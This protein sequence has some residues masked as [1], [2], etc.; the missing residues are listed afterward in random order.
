MNRFARSLEQ[1]TLGKKL[2]SGFILLMLF[3]IGVGLINLRAQQTLIA[4]IKQLNDKEL[5]GVSAARAAQVQYSTIGRGLR[6]ALLAGSGPE[7]VIALKEIDE[8]EIALG[9]DINELRATLHQ[10]VNMRRLQTFETELA[11]Y[12][13]NREKVLELM[14]VGH[15]EA[16]RVYLTSAEF[17]APGVAANTAITELAEAKEKQA[18][19][20]VDRAIAEAAHMVR[21]AVMLLTLGTVLSVLIALLVARSIRKPIASIQRA[22]QKLADG[23]L[24]AQVPCTDYANEL[25]EVARSVRVLQQGATAMDNMSWVKGNL[26]EISN[27][28]QSVNSFSELSQALF[29]Q[30]APLVH[31]GHGAFYIHEEDG[32]RLRLLGGYALRE[33]KELNQYFRIGEGLVGQCAMERD[34]ILLTQPPP[35]YVRIGSSLGDAAPVMIAVLPVLRNER[36]LGVLELATYEPLTERQQSL[37]DGV[38]PTLA[39]NLEILERSVRT[40]KLLEETQRQ[41]SAMQEQAATLEE[42]AVELEAQKDSIAATEAWY[43]GILE[44]APDGMMVTDERGIVIMVNP[45][46]QELFGYDERDIVGKPMEMLVPHAIRAKHPSLRQGFLQV[47]Q[48]RTMGGAKGNL[49]GLRKDGSEFPI[50]VGLSRLP[51]IGG[52]GVCV[53][54]SVRDVTERKKQEQEIE[55]LLNEQETIFRN[56]PNGI[57][58]TADG[59]IIRANQRVAEHL[60]YTL[61]DLIGQPAAC[62]YTSSDNYREFGQKAGPV[63]SAGNVFTT[64]WN[65]A[66]KDGGIFMGLI[67][68]QSVSVAGYQRAAIW[69]MEDISERKAAERAVAEERLR[70][71]QILE[72][73]PVGVSI[74]SEDGVAVFANHQMARVMGISVEELLQR[75]TAT[76]WKDPENRQAF[77]AL[78]RRDGI[79]KDYEAD[80]LRPDG[81]IRSVLI[82]ANSMVRENGTQ[83]V[84]WIYDVTE[85]QIAQQAMRIANAEQSAMFEATTLGIAFIKNRS[86]VRS[87]RKLDVLFGTPDGTQ[88]GQTTR[89][90]YASDEEFIQGGDA[91]YAQ[92]S[93]G[94]M[95]Q[96]EQELVRA[97]GTRFWCQLSGAAIDPSDLSKGTVWMLNDVTERKRTEQE[98]QRN[99]QFMEAVLE[100]INSAIYVKD[101]QG[102][103]TFVNSDW[104]RATGLK[105]TEVLGRS[106]LEVNHLGRGQLYHELDMQA[107]N[108]GQLV[109]TEEVAGQG[110]EERFFQVTK[111][112]MK[113]GD[114][115]VGLCSIAFD[116]TQRKRMEAEIQRTNFLTDIALELTGSGYWYVDYS[117]PE[118][119]FQSDR[120]ARI[121]GETIRPDGRYQ[122]DAEWFARLTDAN[123]ETAQLTAERYQGAVEG[124]YDKYDSI[125]AY[126]RPVD[127]AIVWVHAA[128]KLVRDEASGKAL[129]MYGAYQDITQQKENENEI[130]LAREQAV[131][132]NKEQEA[133]FESATLG[134]AFIKDSV[135]VRGNT[136]LGDLFGRPIT[137][138]L[139]Q[140]TRI[141][142]VD[143]AAFEAGGAR[144]YDELARGDIH[145]SE[146][147]FVRADGSVF[148]C[149][150]SGKAVDASDMSRGSVWMLEDITERR[151]SQAQLAERMDELERFQSLTIDR[152]ERMIALKVEINTLLQGAGLPAKYKIVE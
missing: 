106:T 30:L 107:I 69:M 1:W 24:S 12:K 117:D 81:E 36:L 59:V 149:F 146:Q 63:L 134:I 95:H 130:L 126:K 15:D 28:L 13:A 19:D 71:Q 122:L 72:N 85:R 60:G 111:V 136:G 82:S 99:R 102:V 9:N 62:M 61:D 80:M 138:M 29:S 96:R 103:Y 25:G 97:D 14:R 39:M 43:R 86:I 105:R 94:E 88:I 66:R 21:I 115:V 49:S 83:L 118:H 112:P 78:L 91:V 31:I 55:K 144:V 64:E 50:E 135:I 90:W 100:N 67:S 52:R 17:R 57:V 113:Q 11:V 70:L 129:F 121:L 46:L 119:Y 104:E 116:V 8:A 18:R 89:S 93:R 140:T 150:M 47:G 92:L 143:E 141:W 37:L 26:A 16:A 45:R 142:Y 40:N 133:I 58:Y 33:R 53:C 151:E 76:L 109:V 98:I 124:R 145:Q 34:S 127:G 4:Q 132:T 137:D 7:R 148:W 54:A 110:T 20:G 6:Q 42:Q 51:A 32:H 74:N 101:V 65:F 2:A 87:N 48:S 5:L 22:V 23:E 27:A 139:G 3:A 10:S 108:A 35:D 41:S 68:G 44:S 125:Y 56:A 123:P 128:G 147:E 79:V 38:M 131:E 152:E 84:S 73:S 75:N 77:I 120:A 114:E